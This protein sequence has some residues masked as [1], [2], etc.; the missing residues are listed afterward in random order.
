MR[1]LKNQD[2]KGVEKS[3]SNKRRSKFTFFNSFST[4]IRRI[5]NCPLD[6]IK[7]GKMHYLYLV[8][9]FVRPM[10][11]CLKKKVGSEAVDQVE[12]SSQISLKVPFPHVLL[13]V[14]RKYLILDILFTD[15]V[16]K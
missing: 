10:S 8:N 9:H 6:I 16:T 3:T 14:S 12:P 1:T 11:I 7:D 4:S 5:R 13:R 15:L 2:R